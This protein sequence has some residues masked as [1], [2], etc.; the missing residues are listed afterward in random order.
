MPSPDSTIGTVAQVQLFLFIS[1]SS[2]CWLSAARGSTSIAD[3]GFSPRVR[4]GSSRCA[5]VIVSCSRSHGGWYWPGKLVRRKFTSNFE[6]CAT[7][8]PL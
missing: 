7:Q 8:Q 5:S 4:V 2:T 6:L 3:S 1:L